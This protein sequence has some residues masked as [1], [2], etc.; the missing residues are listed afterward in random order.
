MRSLVDDRRL[1]VFPLSEGEIQITQFDFG[2]YAI[3]YESRSAFVASELESNCARRFAIDLG[4]PEILSY[5]ENLA[6][7]AR[8]K[9]TLVPRVDL[10]LKNKAVVPRG[11]LDREV[12]VLVD[13]SSMDRRTLS[14]IL[15]HL[16]VEPPAHLTQ[17]YVT[18]APATFTSPPREMLP[19]Q[20]SGPV[21]D[22]LSGAP[23][24]PGLP[25]VLFVGLGYELGL[26]LGMVETFEPASVFAYVP[27]GTDKRFDRQVDRVNLPLFTDRH[28]VNRIEYGVNGPANT[29]ID[30]KER[31]LAVKDKSRVV[32]VPSGP[33]LFSAI[34][35]LCGYI[36]SPDICVWRVS[37]RL[38]EET[39]QKYADG[40][41]VAFRVQINSSRR[42]A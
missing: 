34:S 37:S 19:V 32:L 10:A 23:K 5:L 8:R 4:G 18:Y 24:D 39:A 36:Y 20:F 31:L 27:R 42:E 13:I 2:Y 25:T 6:S 17:L 41:I 14:F 38:Q 3:G 1:S 28:F 33:K 7:A 40:S 11:R 12:R 29:L 16:L 21:N 35:I 9:D 22:L 15:Y 26:A 30:L